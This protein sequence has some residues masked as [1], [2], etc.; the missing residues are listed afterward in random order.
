MTG[1]P[2]GRGRGLDGP[3]CPEREHLDQ[4]YNPPPRQAMCVRCG[5][6]T[7]RRDTD[8]LPWCGGTDNEGAS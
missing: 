5:R 2:P 8:S 7:S 3:A 1:R 4:G 6:V